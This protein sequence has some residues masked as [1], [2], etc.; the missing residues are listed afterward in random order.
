MADIFCICHLNYP[1]KLYPTLTPADPSTYLPVNIGVKPIFHK[2]PPSF[3]IL[4]Y[5]KDAVTNT[6]EPLLL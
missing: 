1:L 4:L 2:K 6:E 5:I 3:G